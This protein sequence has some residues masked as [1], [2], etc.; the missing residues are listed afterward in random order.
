MCTAKNFVLA[1]T[2]LKFCNVTRKINKY[3]YITVTEIHQ[4]AN[5]RISSTS[6]E[7]LDPQLLC[8]RQIRV[9]GIGKI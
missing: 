2:P 5:V 7:A 8:S 4:Y 9:K 1:G 3:Y 6:L